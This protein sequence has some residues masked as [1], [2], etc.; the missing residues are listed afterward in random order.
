MAFVV[1]RFGDAF[2]EQYDITGI[3]YIHVRS[4][5]GIISFGIGQKNAFVNNGM[6]RLF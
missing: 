6:K 4:I 5:H 1:C 2:I 3:I